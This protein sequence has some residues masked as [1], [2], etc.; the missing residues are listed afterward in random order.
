MNFWNHISYKVVFI[1]GYF[2]IPMLSFSIE[3]LKNTVNSINNSF[4]PKKSMNKSTDITE[5]HLYYHKFLHQYKF[6]HIGYML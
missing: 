3:G 4:N 1:L 6:M 5:I 2:K